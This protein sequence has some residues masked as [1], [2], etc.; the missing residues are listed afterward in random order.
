MNTAA[1]A[2]LGEHDFRSFCKA[3]SV[4]LLDEAGRS[5]SRCVTK[6]EVSQLEEAGEQLVVVDVAGN[7]FLHNMVRIITGS[8]VEVGR[9][10]REPDWLAKALQACNCSAAGPTAPAE[11][12]C[13][14][15]V[16]YPCGVLKP[17]D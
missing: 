3:S 5:T 1:T 16:D 4:A 2:L 15:A 10:H 14:A 11:G 9:G 17:W 6:L 13:F 7:A 8:L 12:L